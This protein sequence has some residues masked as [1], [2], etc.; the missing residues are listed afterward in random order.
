MRREF[1]DH[2]LVL[3]RDDVLLEQHP[4]QIRRVKCEVRRATVLRLQ[5]AQLDPH[6]VIPRD[7]QRLPRPRSAALQIVPRPHLHAHFVRPR[8]RVVFI[9]P[10]QIDRI[11][12]LEK[13]H[14]RLRWQRLGEHSLRGGEIFLHMGRRQREHRADPLKAVPRLVLRESRRVRGVVRH[15]EQIAHGI[16][17]FLAREFVKAHALAPRE[18]RGFALLQIPRDPFHDLRFVR[19]FRLLLIIGRH[20]AGADAFQHIRPMLHVR[21]LRKIPRERI[22]PELAFVLLL[23]V[24]AVAVLLQKWRERPVKFRRLRG[25]AEGTPRQRHDH[26][27]GERKMACG[28]C[29]GKDRRTRETFALGAVESARQSR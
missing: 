25:C 18:T 13:F 6:F 29:S 2:R 10:A 21:T 3:R 23:I 12:V 24:A 9:P 17:V 5:P 28:H 8:F 26:G 27:E 14:R 1:H 15:A 19:G 16:H 7:R 22:Q 20:V 4:I 11:L